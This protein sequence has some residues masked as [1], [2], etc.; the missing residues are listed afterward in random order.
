M[1]PVNFDIRAESELDHIAY[2]W[3]VLEPAG[4]QVRGPRAGRSHDSGHTVTVITPPESTPCRIVT[5]TVI[6]TL[7]RDSQ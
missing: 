7:S 6:V 5:V 1:L 2:R 3:P 4:R